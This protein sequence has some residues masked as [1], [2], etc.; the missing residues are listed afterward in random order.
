MTPSDWPISG[1]P[2]PPNPVNGGVECTEIT[3]TSS[4]SVPPP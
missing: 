4:F 3:G 1:P 2:P